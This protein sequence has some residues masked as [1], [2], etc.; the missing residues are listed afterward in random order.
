MTLVLSTLW[1]VFHVYSSLFERGGIQARQARLIAALQRQFA[2]DLQCAIED[3]PRPNDGPTSSSV[4]RFGLQGGAHS[5]RFD[6]LQMLP[7]DQ[8][9]ASE[10]SSS[11][12]RASATV[13]QVPEL[14]TVGYR[15]V[16]RRHLPGLPGG[17]PR[18]D[19]AQSG[20][21]SSLEAPRPNPG[22]TRWEIDFETPLERTAGRTLP[23]Q[24]PIGDAGLQ[25]P[26]TGTG[27]T[28]FEDLAAQ[29]TAPEAITWLPEVRRAAFRYFDGRAW[30]D[31]WK[32]LHARL[33]AGGR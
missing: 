6:V 8:L 9:P 2:D 24:E 16:S 22:L 19:A 30:S 13:P 20:N 27:G 17:S 26:S 4:R 14:R 7:D 28:S 33:L 12:G 15:F 5:L 25:P 11:L 21:D 18:E 29:A 23:A 3:S 32:K 31:S 1:E 10:S